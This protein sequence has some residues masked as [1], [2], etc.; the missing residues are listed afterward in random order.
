MSKDDIKL[1]TRF[2]IEV[3]ESKIEGVGVFATR[4][5]EKDETVGVITGLLV[6]IPDPHCPYTLEYEDFALEPTWPFKYL[7]HSS[8]PNTDGEIVLVATKRIAK[9]DEITMDYGDEW[10]NE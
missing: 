5:F 3:R 10:N 7:N 2:G 1:K 6:E 4:A 8:D 9:G